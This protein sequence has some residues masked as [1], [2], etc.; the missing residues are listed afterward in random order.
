M[1]ILIYIIQGILITLGSY[2]YCDVYAWKYYYDQVK[3]E[4]CAPQSRESMR[5]V[6]VHEIG[7]KYWNE[8]MTSA[9]KKWYIEIYNE[10]FWDINSYYREYSMTN[11]EEDF[12]DTFMYV[13]LW[14]SLER[15]EW[16]Y[17]KVK[18]IENN[19][20]ILQNSI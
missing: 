10:N 16:F 18:Y 17:D 15:N 5:D 7:H 12:A 11:I 4:I 9:E 13:I 14:K 19:L 3:I 8:D 1:N 20:Q 2:G 6:L